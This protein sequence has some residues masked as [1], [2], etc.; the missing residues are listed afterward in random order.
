MCLVSG[1]LSDSNYTIRNRSTRLNT[2]NKNQSSNGIE[3][4]D[5]FWF[6]RVHVIPSTI[7]F[8][9]YTIG[10]TADLDIYNANQSGVSVASP[11]A[12]SPIELS[13]QTFP[14]D[15]DGLRSVRLSVSLDN[16][17]AQVVDEFVT[18]SD[19][20]TEDSVNILGIISAILFP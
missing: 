16:S 12:P 17:Q 6:D 7:D 20:V 5:F 3:I 8:E 19:G 14:L 2:L 13:G 18:F 15:I 1:L 4:G 11:N 9:T 10:E